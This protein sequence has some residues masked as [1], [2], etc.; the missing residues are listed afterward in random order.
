MNEIGGY[1]E[2][3]LQKKAEYYGDAIKLNTCRNAIKYI[4]LAQGVKTVYVPYLTC[5][6]VLESM[7][8]LGIPYR[9]Y[10]IDAKLEIAGIRPQELREDEKILYINYFGVKNAHVDTLAERFGSKLIVDNTQAFYKVPVGHTDTCYSPRKFFGLP[11]GGYL[12][13]DTVLD[14]ELETD[15]SYDRCRDL[16]GRLDT[17]AAT[18]YAEYVKHNESLIGLPMKKMSTLTQKLL[19]SIDYEKARLTRERNYR[20]LHDRLN[21]LNALEIDHS[22]IYGPMVYPLLI[23]TEGLRE[24]LISEKIYVAT[25]WKEVLDFVEEPGTVEEKMVRYLL[26]LPIDQRYGSDDMERIASTVMTYLD[27]QGSIRVK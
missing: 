18:F 17:D 3:E 22:D 12:Y 25:Y 4:L 26:P 16:L 20:Y 23:E 6:S 11:D 13:T 5:E 1:F 15:I 27:G 9:F 24:H 21:T 19:A 14:E 10:S 2:L 7:K 8:T